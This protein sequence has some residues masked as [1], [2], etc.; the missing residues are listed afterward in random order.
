MDSARCRPHRH[1]AAADRAYFQVYQ[2][3]PAQRASSSGRRRAA[4]PPAQW[5]LSVAR[6]VA[7][8]GGSCARC[9]VGRARAAV[10]RAALARRRPR[11]QRRGRPVP[12]QRA[13]AGAQPRAT[14]DLRGRDLSQPAAVH[15]RPAA[16]RRRAVFIRES[17]LDGV[18]R[19]IAYRQLPHLSGPGGG[20]RLRLSRDAGALAPL[21]H[22]DRRWSGPAA[23]ADRRSCSPCSCGARR[24]AANRP[25]C[26]S[27]SWRRPCRRSSSS[28]TSAA[29]C[30]SSAS[31][32]REV[33]G[34][35]AG[36]CA[37]ARAGRRLVHPDDRPRWSRSSP[38][39]MQR[40]SELQLEHRL[41]YRDGSYRWQLLRAVP[42][43]EAEQAAASWFGTAT[44]ID[45]LKQAQQRLHEQAEQLRMAGRL[46]RMGSWRA[47]LGH[48]AR[49]RCPRRRRRS[50]DLPP[51]AE[52]LA[53][54]GDGD[55]RAASRCAGRAAMR[56]ATRGAGAPF[57]V[58]VEMVTRHRPP[59]LDPHAGR[60]G[61]RRR[62]A[63]WWRCRA[64]SRTSRCGC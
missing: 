4:A 43:R 61:A 37:R 2:R 50:L 34:P 41:R 20:G 10:L 64:R 19:V 45:A 11:R 8:A 14:S 21:R 17:R 48:A 22:A 25:S 60:A 32:G 47:D 33:T 51:D 26:A 49:D 56:R 54:G 58:E 6:A 23:V 16:R 5:M 39:H 52:P 40:A 12:P 53:A 36:R 44:D 42:V 18:M 15:A 46:T 35:P 55:A 57:D 13:A 38:A 1:V 59:R 28:P 3:E 9:I 62:A 29:R 24:A 63:R 7:R 30:S 27:G 31:A